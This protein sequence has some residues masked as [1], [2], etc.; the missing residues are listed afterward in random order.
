MW[1]YEAVTST[2]GMVNPSVGKGQ[3]YMT[4]KRDANGDL[5]RADR[6][7]RLRVPPDAP[8]AQFWSLTL[9]SENARRAYESGSGTNASASRDSAN[10]LVVNNDGSVDLFIGPSAP[11]GLEKNHMPTVEDDG[12]FVYFRLYG[13]LEPWFDKTWSLPDFEPIDG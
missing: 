4:T 6:T 7:Y 9:Y 8:V 3:V 5:L 11:Q 13:P 12:W 2:K 10:D 1:F